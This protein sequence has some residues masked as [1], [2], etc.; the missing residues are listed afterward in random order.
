M[1]RNG[2]TIMELMIV[3]AIIGILAAIAIPLFSGFQNRAREAAVKSNCHTLQLA[4]EDF[5]LQNDGL[6]ATDTD[7]DQTTMG[8][9]LRDLLPGG[10]ALENPYTV[11]RTEPSSSGVATTPGQIGYV[12][13]LGA[14]GVAEG[15][16]ITGYGSTSIVLTV[17]NGN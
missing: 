9:T 15:Y 5:A 8:D 3:C 10:V 14:S 16:S 13:V 7:T 1:R 12:P 6:Y 11:V 4:A 17:T 2:F